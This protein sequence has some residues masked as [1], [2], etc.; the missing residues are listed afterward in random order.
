EPSNPRDQGPRR[1][2]GR[3]AGSSLP[4][5]GHRGSR[6]PIR[7]VQTCRSRL[8]WIRRIDADPT[9]RR[10]QAEAGR[11]REPPEARGAANQRREEAM[12]TTTFLT[13]LI[14][15][16]LLVLAALAADHV[17]SRLHL[18]RRWG[19]TVALA[20]TVGIMAASPWLGAV[21]RTWG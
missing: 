11:P 19:W 5:C 13:G 9:H 4:R 7:G 2:C 21:T 6:A 1:P 10:S 15:A 14:A 17:I 3:R 16:S 18:A 12:I 8:R 20:L